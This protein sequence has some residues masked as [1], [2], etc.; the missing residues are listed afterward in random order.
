MELGARLDLA[1]S[2]KHIGG[3][4][5]GQHVAPRLGHPRKDRRHLRDGLAGGK[6]HFRHAGAQRAVMV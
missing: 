5:R 3:S 4:A 6:N 1:D 2:A